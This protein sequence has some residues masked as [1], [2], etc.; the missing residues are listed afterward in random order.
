MST[1]HAVILV[2]MGPIVKHADADTLGVTQIDGRPCVI[3]LSEWS[4]G[5]LAIY[6]PIDSM[7]PV[8]DHRFAFLASKADVAGFARIQAMRLRGVFSMGLLVKPLSQEVTAAR[9]VTDLREYM[10]IELFEP[11]EPTDPDAI[12]D[13]GFIPRYTDMESARKWG[14]V[15]FQPGEEVVLVEKIHGETVRA[16]F[17]DGALWVAS[18]LNFKRLGLVP[19]DART[20]EGGFIAQFHA[21]PGAP[22]RANSW[23]RLAQAGAFY[24]LRKAPEFAFFGEIYGNVSGMRYNATSDVPKWAAFDAVE[25]AT[26]RWLD[27]DDFRLLANRLSLPVAPELYRGPWKPG[28]EALAE[29]PTLLGGDHVREGW[30]G[31]PV[32]ERFDSRVGRVILKRHG[33]G[34]L[35]RKRRKS[36]V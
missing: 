23:A 5:D 4:E 13:P 24:G 26:R 8:S 29:G 7:V 28:L 36:P 31:R 30:V 12:K 17:R 35:T 11:P 21:A 25:I 22:S 27:Y 32:K 9:D 34:Y 2:R 33:E 6:V 1:E 15:L 18:A 10:G 16:A 20:W 3:R 14:D 19:E